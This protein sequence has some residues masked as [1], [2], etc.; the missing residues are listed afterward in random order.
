MSLPPLWPRPAR[1]QAPPPPAP[2]RAGPG[3]HFGQSFVMVLGP[4]EAARGAWPVSAAPTPL[5][6][7]SRRVF[8]RGPVVLRFGTRPAFPCWLCGLGAARDRP[9][10]R[11]GPRWRRRRGVVRT[12]GGSPPPSAPLRAHPRPSAA[13][14]PLP[15]AAARG[16]LRGRAAG[17][18]EG[19]WGRGASFIV[20]CFAGK[21][22]A[23]DTA[24]APP[25]PLRSRSAFCRVLSSSGAGRARG[26]GGRKDG[27]DRRVPPG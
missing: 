12:P 10:A 6:P 13:G 23:P 19:G 21:F 27:P 4:Q 7:A 8:P 11:P 16:S 18:G 9:P 26:G 24:R 14:S 22:P 25:R 17:P 3:S 1:S 5:L 20:S 2:G 15:K